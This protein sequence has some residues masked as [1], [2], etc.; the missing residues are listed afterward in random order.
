MQKNIAKP[1]PLGVPKG[2][3]FSISASLYTYWKK[4]FERTKRMGSVSGRTV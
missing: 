1:P 4:S 3:V 2:G